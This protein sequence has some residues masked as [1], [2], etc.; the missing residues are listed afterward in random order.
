M[1]TDMRVTLVDPSLYTAPYDAA[2]TTGLL[3]AGVQP[4][5]MTRPA[6]PGERQQ[7]PPELTETVFYRRVDQARW[8]PAA[9]RPLAKGCAHAAGS[10]RLART[11]LLSRPDVVHVQW[12]VVPALDI[13]TMALFR[14][15]GPL[16]LTVH[17]THAD[18]GDEVPWLRSLGNDLP[19]KLAHQVI[20]HTGAGREAL[21]E[22]GVPADRVCVIPHGPLR[23]PGGGALPAARDGRWTVVLFGEIKPY[24]GLD[25]LIDAVAALSAPLRAALRIVVAG[26]PRMDL[27]PLVS[28]I[29]ALGLQEQFEVRAHRLSEEEMAAL[30]AETDC[31]VLPYR[32]VDASGVYYLVNSLG[33]WLIASRVG[34]FAEDMPGRA[35]GALVPP[36]DAAALAGALRHAIETRPRGCARGHAHTWD[37][38]GWATRALYERALAAF[39]G[40]R[41][42][43]RAGFTPQQ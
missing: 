10:V 32:Q 36:G 7:L 43:S 5:W 23:P 3:S 8:L 28:R 40:P 17:D 2:L 27:A 20:V 6:R 19:A 42:E 37:E 1:S 33:K 26:R 11:I 4:T 39:H 31:F 30:F 29:A 35:G 25:I 14:R 24:K 15:L 16:V 12:V 9:L 21:I 18:N 38:I 41:V 22:R 13:A 34:I